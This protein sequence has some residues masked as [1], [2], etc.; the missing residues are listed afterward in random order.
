MTA[1]Q[2][3]SWT[4]EERGAVV[5]REMLGK[6]PKLYH[7]RYLGWSR[8]SYQVGPLDTQ[9]RSKIRTTRG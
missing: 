7:N 2:I 8:N 6:T 9:D 1:G 3:T 4:L 5:K